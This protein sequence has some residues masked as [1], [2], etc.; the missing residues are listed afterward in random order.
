MI[1]TH[2]HTYI[3]QQDWTG[4]GERGLR[5]YLIIPA[6]FFG[7]VSPGLFISAALFD[8]VP[9]LWIALG[10]NL[11]GY[12]ITHL[13]YLG[14]MERFWRAM[15]NW[16]TSWISRG[17]IFNALFSFFGFI[18]ALSYTPHAAALQGHPIQAVSRI[19]SILSA[20]LFAAYPGFMLRTVKAI[21]FW[22]SFIE[23]VL[24]FLQGLLGGVALHVLLT[25]FVYF[26]AGTASVLVK[27]DLILAQTVFVLFMAALLIKA[28]H[29]GVE[30][31]SVRFLTTG[32]FSLLF[33]GGAIAAGLVLPIFLIMAGVLSGLE[34]M[35]HRAWYSVA[36]V[37]E[38]AGIYFGKFSVL[39]AGI[40]T[41]IVDLPC[42][43]SAGNLM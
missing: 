25:S 37:L 30:K 17:F 24:F 42:G 28:R 38:L 35:D 31:A 18:H 5:D 2:R 26:D 29:G 21:P 36:M 34:V 32:E 19:I 7:A 9:G 8:F 10:M 20:V 39:R 33:L 1:T 14:R 15:L 16:R 23:P 27:A 3:F 11:I 13:L 4:K 22:R 43:K 41:P 12:G 6:I 40:Y